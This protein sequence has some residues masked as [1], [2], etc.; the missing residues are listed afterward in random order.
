MEI[1]NRIV[2]AAQFFLSVIV[3]QSSDSNIIIP[4]V[5]TGRR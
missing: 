5:N 4:T 3:A 1:S 2:V